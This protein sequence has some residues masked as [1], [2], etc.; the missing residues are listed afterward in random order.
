MYNQNRI[1]SAHV[2]AKN[3]SDL[4]IITYMY[5]YFKYF[6]KESDNFLKIIIKIHILRIHILKP[7]LN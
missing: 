3:E 2:I 6:S 7:S 1:I 4:I 5:R